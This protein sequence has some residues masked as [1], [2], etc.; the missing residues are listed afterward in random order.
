MNCPS[1]GTPIEGVVTR[2]PSDHV[3]D[4]CGCRATTLTAR[5][6]ATADADRGRGVATDGGI[7]DS[8]GDARTETIDVFLGKVRNAWGRGDE[9]VA[10]SMEQAKA[11]VEARARELA[12]FIDDADLPDDAEWR[13]HSME[14]GTQVWDVED[15]QIVVQTHR[16]EKR[17]ETEDCAVCGMPVEADPATG[18]ATVTAN[19][20]A[21]AEC[22]THDETDVFPDGG[23][24]EAP[25]L[26]PVSVRV[27]VTDAEVTWHTSDT[28]YERLANHPSGNLV[29]TIEDAAKDRDGSL[30]DA[31]VAS[32]GAFWIM[33]VDD[34]E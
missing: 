15:W 19:G 26:Y 7:P 13:D 29:T 11:D 27:E 12:S 25:D 33:E 34:D 6:F 28:A 23:I 21:H 2:G 22:A 31:V 30:F 3:L 20:L 5:E 18:D 4:P 8:E 17:P 32:S 1:C 16:I 10:G 24:A 9:V 14:E